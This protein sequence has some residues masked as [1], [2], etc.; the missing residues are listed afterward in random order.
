MKTIVEIIRHYDALVPF[1]I[2]AAKIRKAGYDVEEYSNSLIAELGRAKDSGDPRCQDLLRKIH[3]MA[4][5]NQAY[6]N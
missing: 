5:S 3:L 2:N 1:P 4:Y 6:R